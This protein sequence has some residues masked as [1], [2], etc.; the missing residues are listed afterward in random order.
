MKLE[1]LKSSFSKDVFL[2]SDSEG[3]LVLS[4]LNNLSPGIYEFI[5][6]A[7]SENNSY[8]FSFKLYHYLLPKNLL[9]FAL[10]LNPPLSD[11]LQQKQA[12]GISTFLRI[13]SISVCLRTVNTN[14]APHIRQLK[15]LSPLSVIEPPHLVQSLFIV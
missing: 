9:G 10:F 6:V 14:T 4:E 15:S 13:P 2:S 1:S 12:A 5:I 11:I 7:E 8:S 3:E